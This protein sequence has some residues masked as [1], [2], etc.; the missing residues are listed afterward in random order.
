M[1]IECNCPNKCEIHPKPKV[2]TIPVKAVMPDF[3]L[4][5]KLTLK[6]LEAG[7]LK[8]QMEIQNAVNVARQKYMAAQQQ[9]DAFA[10]T[11]FEKFGLKQED[12]ILDL[13]K[14]VFTPRNPEK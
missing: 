1:A 6:T 9:L 8:A 5:D 10:A 7:S 2:T 11:M 12:Y 4:E 13:A 14:L 3:E